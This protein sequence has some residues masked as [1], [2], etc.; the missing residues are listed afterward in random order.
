MNGTA[1]LTEEV[2]VLEHQSEIDA[3][4]ALPSKSIMPALTLR[5]SCKQTMKQTFLNIFL[6]KKISTFLFYTMRTLSPSHLDITRAF[7]LI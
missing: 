4:Y 5:I 1:I 3:A 7:I 2:E 6:K